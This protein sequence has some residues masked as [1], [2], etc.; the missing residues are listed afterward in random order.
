MCLLVIYL[1]YKSNSGKMF[2]KPSH[3]YFEIES[4]SKLNK[5]NI[6]QVKNAKCSKVCQWLL[7]VVTLHMQDE[8]VNVRTIGI[9]L[10]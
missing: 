8:D 10:N 5:S 6:S 9:L 3:S 4:L 2:K 1:I 7:A